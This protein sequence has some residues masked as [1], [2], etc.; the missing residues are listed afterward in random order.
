MKQ[1]F[2]LGLGFVLVAAAGCTTKPAELPVRIKVNREV[3]FR[4]LKNFRPTV[5]TAEEASAHPSL[6]RLARELVVGELV[7]R[8]F[9]R[10]ENGSPDFRVRAHLR[11]SSYVGAKM[12][13][14]K[15]TGEATMS[16]ED[17]RD[18]TLIVEIIDPD[19][20]MSYWLGMVSGF[21]LDPINSRASLKGAAWRLMAEFPPLF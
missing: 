4:S 7:S 19:D 11:F 10:L 21:Q 16:E 5:D 6:Q 18:V 1:L 13:A 8:G 2:A 12:G 20:D 9:E 14:G 17:V 3:D 15:T